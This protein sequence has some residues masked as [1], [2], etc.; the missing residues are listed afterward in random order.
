MKCFGLFIPEEDLCERVVT[1]QS[2][3]ESVCEGERLEHH[4]S[5]RRQSL[6]LGKLLISPFEDFGVT[7][8]AGHGQ[9]QILLL[10]ESFDCHHILN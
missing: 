5:S 10:L 1:A 9:V 3:V 2:K 8:V 7:N 6:Q 4:R